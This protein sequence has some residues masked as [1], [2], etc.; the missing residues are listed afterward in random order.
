MGGPEKAASESFRRLGS[1]ALDDRER[2]STRLGF[3]RI[4]VIA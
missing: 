1:I 3:N 4:E 2:R